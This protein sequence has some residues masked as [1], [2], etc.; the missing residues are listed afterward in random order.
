M[1]LTRALTG[2]KKSFNRVLIKLYKGFN[3]VLHAV[4]KSAMHTRDPGVDG[5]WV[6]PRPVYTRV[7][8]YT[9]TKAYELED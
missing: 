3:K 2:F 6:H 8:G 1:G 5:S 4:Q 9:L 7:P